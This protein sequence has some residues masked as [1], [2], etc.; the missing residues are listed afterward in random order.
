MPFFVLCAV[1]VLGPSLWLDA[2]GHVSRARVERKREDVRIAS[3]GAWTRAF[4]L[5]V[6]PAGETSPITP[7]VSVDEAR[8]DRLRVGDTVRVR[9]VACCPIFARLA[10]RS[11][12]DWMRDLAPM[13]LHGGRWVIWLVGGIAVLAFAGRRGTAFLLAAAVAWG[14]AALALDR[15]TP[16]PLPNDGP[17]RAAARVHAVRTVEYALSTS[18]RDDFE[19][20][21]PY[22]VA[23][24]AFV[25]APG[26][27]TVV[28]VDAVDDG[29][30]PQLV[31]GGTVPVRFDPARPR[32]ATID[33]GDRSYVDRNRPLFIAI[34]GG[35]FALATL[36]GLILTRKQPR[37]RR[38]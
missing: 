4:L 11:T 22:D 20:P 9:T 32:A 16:G 8:Y 10:D 15:A 3:D 38:R 7:T 12:L 28:A 5:D 2:N 25:P 1:L 26:A 34:V 6:A 36:I 35:V 31:M 21:Q 27:D 19:L 30:M 29:T 37:R 33:G 18:R 13:V 14:V 23:E 17:L 24:L